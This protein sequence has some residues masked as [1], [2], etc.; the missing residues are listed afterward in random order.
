MSS[1]N[2]RNFLKSSGIA[3]LPAV[4]P[5]TQTFANDVK[6][7]WAPG[8]PIIKFYGD[9]E[10]FEPADYLNELQNANAKL[11]IEKDSYGAGGAVEALEKKFTDITGKERAVFMP[12]GT[13]ANQLAIAVLSGDNTKVFV[14]DASHVYRDEADAAQSVFQKR[15]MP[16]AMGETGF[17]ADQLKKAVESLGD[18]EVF[19]SGIG[20]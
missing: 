12:S 4:I 8:S 14:Q 1:I 11:A 10:M 7:P 2:R 20:A 6:M 3:A 13:M 5:F 19:K 18:Q 16:L 17:T 9:G 15:L